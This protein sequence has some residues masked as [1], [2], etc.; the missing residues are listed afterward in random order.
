MI[1]FLGIIFLLMSLW[2]IFL[3]AHLRT[4]SCKRDD[5]NQCI[6]NIIESGLLW[7]K[8]IFLGE[9]IRADVETITTPYYSPYNM[10]N[11]SY[12]IILSASMYNFSFT[13]DRSINIKKQET[14]ALRINTFIN[15]PG[16]KHLTVREDTRLLSCCSGAIAIAAG[17]FFF[18]Q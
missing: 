5:N 6:C 2:I 16:Q 17:L 14:I 18:N 3:S 9:L 13:L 8:V 7:S 12:G 4:L 1:Q 10:F 11:T 15:D